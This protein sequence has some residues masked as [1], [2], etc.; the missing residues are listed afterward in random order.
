MNASQDWWRRAGEATRQG[1]TVGFATICPT[2]HRPMGKNTDW[3]DGCGCPLEYLLDE[4]VL[5]AHGINPHDS[6]WYIGTYRKKP[7]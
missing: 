5:L 2:H 4:Q 6:A 7:D 1:L 3:P